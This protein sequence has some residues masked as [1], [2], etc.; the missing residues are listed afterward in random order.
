MTRL[1]SEHLA[2][3]S[4][5]GDSV[6]G[7]RERLGLDKRALADAAGVHR[8]TLSAIENGD[9]FNRSTLTKVERAL[10]SFEE[11]AGIGAPPLPAVETPQQ[12]HV[13]VRV[14]N[15]LGEV[16][17]EGPVEDLEALQLNAVRALRALTE[18]PDI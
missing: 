17:V 10:E 15:D 14:K 4:H 16:V 18:N 9:S 11:E 1:S 5:E 8:N 12:H 3:M 13:I 2:H 6:R 7:R